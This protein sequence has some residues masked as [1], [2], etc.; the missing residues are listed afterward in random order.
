[1]RTVGEELRKP[2]LG[3][4]DGIGARNSERRKAVLAR[5]L[6]QRSLERGRIGQKSRSA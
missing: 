6:R 1:M 5:Y 4:G 3:V 2:G